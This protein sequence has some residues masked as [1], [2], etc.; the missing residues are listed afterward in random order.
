MSPT[1]FPKLANLIL[2]VKKHVFTR[3]MQIRKNS[4]KK[5]FYKTIV[6]QI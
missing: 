3:N 5:S 2:F 6:L 4:K 1:K